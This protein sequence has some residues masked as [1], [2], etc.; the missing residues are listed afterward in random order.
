[1]ELMDK[2]S[3]YNLATTKEIGACLANGSLRYEDLLSPYWSRGIRF[4]DGD[5]D[6]EDISDESADVKG[7]FFQ[8]HP[9]F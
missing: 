1:M 2:L 5:S 4:A 7:E 8:R 3:R 9:Y 6:D